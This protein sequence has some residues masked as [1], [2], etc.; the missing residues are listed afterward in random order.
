MRTFFINVYLI[1]DRQKLGR[2][3]LLRSEADAMVSHYKQEAEYDLTVHQRQR[4][5]PI[6]RY[7]VRM[8]GE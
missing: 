8:K 6:Y 5:L 7:N 2:A 4:V 1:G 3:N